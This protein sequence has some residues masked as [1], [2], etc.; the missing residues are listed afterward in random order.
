MPTLIPLMLLIRFVPLHR[1]VIGKPSHRPPSALHLTG[2]L[3]LCSVTS[4][5]E[6]SHDTAAVFNQQRSAR[7]SLSATCSMHGQRNGGNM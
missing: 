3:P 4:P 7:W 6:A 2:R 5:Y 1:V